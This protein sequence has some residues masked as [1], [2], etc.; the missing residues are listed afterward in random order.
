VYLDIT[1]NLY[2]GTQ[3]LKAFYGDAVTDY[4]QTRDLT[5]IG[6]Q[7]DDSLEI[8]AIAPWQIENLDASVDMLFNSNSFVEMPR[9]VVQNYV[10]KVME[11]SPEVVIGLVSYDNNTDST[12]PPD[13]LPSFF[14]AR[15]FNR[16]HYPMY[17]GACGAF[18]YTSVPK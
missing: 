18:M 9:F 12:I 13:D 11:K 15:S 2:V 5:R 3:Y 14:P 6:F 1:P 7:D 16:I 8:L 17:Q 10:S 4:R